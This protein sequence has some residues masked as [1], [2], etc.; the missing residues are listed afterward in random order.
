MKTIKYYLFVVWIALCSV[1]AY[2]QEK[3]R[4]DSLKTKP[5]TTVQKNSEMPVV[6]PDEKKP[7]APIPQK[8]V[9]ENEDGM[10]VKNFPD[11]TM[12]QPER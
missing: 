11:S 12:K 8:K 10:P 2:G 7:A 3:P 6:K 1:A 4:V 9:R 5:D